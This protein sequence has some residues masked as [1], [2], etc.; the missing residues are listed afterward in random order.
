MFFFATHFSCVYRELMPPPTPQHQ[1]P[2][3]HAHPS[4]STPIHPLPSIS[5]ARVRE[6][7][8]TA[9]ANMPPVEPGDVMSLKHATPQTAPLGKIAGGSGVPSGRAVSPQ[10]P[11][12]KALPSTP[13]TYLANAQTTQSCN[14]LHTHAPYERTNNIKYYNMRFT[15]KCI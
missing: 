15:F 11:K 6:F 8:D 4:S 3:N 12:P 2:S 13:C 7:R 9:Y 10:K 14:H 5:P 1:N